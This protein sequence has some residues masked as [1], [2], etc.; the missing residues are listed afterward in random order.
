MTKIDFGIITGSGFYELEEN[1]KPT[2][3]SI[4][5]QWGIVEVEIVDYQNKKI[6]FI[7]RHGKNHRLLPNMINHRANIAALNMCKPKLIIATTVCGILN[8]KLELGKLLLF[9]DLFF[10]ENRLPSGELCSMY[11]KPGDPKRG[12]YICTSHF[13]QATIQAIKTDDVYT[14]VTYAH[15]NGPRFN[16]KTEISYI[17]QYAD[18]VSQTSGPEAILTG[19]CEIPYVLLGCGIDYANG[20]TQNPTPIDVLNENLKKSTQIFK[21]KILEIIQLQAQPSFEGFV[22]RFE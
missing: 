5:T 13:H 12:H 14:D 4:E 8:P 9:T 6:G 3:Q 2:I 20:V 22:Y 11:T 7:P 21:Q 15:A 19:E 10:P 16:S 18:A 17:A 1:T